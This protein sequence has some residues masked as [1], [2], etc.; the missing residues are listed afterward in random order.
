MGYNTRFEGHFEFD[1]P[2]APL[3]F[4]YLSAFARTRRMQRDPERLP[5]DGLHAQV[6]IG[7]GCDGG[8]FVGDLGADERP[9]GESVVN[10]NRPPRGQPSLWCCWR[11]IDIPV[12]HVD[13]PPVEQ[14]SARYLGWNPCGPSVE[15]VEWLE[16]LI[17]SFIEPWG[18]VLRGRV[19]WFG[20]DPLDVGHIQV[21]RNLVSLPAPSW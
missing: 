8:F 1:R 3:H 18:Y 17:G 10:P 20:E 9:H 7:S 16:Y 11:P 15:Y 5:A 4:Q 13:Q 21:R 2:L 6:G 14:S 12:R 19:V